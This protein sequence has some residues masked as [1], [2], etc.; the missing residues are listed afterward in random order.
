VPTAPD[1]R[2]D[3]DLVTADVVGPPRRVVDRVDPVLVAVV[4]AGVVLRWVGLGA[5]SLW[6]DEWLTS[7]A[8]AGSLPDLF[9]HVAHREGIPPTYFVVEWAWVR[10]AGDGEV[11][12]RTLSALFGA[13]TVP[14]AYAV[15]AE[16]RQPRAAARGAAVLVAVS[17]MLVWY[18][19][20]ARPYS[21][22]ALLG[23]VSFLLFARVWRDDA[24]RHL[25]V[26]AAVAAATVAVHYFAAFL[27]ATE[28]LA[29]LARRPPQWRRLLLAA[30]PSAGVLALLAP[31]AVTQHSHDANRLWISG[32]PLGDR[33]E[34]AGRSALVG[35]SPVHGRLW[36]AVAA[37]VAVAAV[38]LVGSGDRA[39][40]SAAALAAGVGGAALVPPLVLAAA[41]GDD[42]VVG[43]YL[44]ASL[45]PL[46]AAVAIGL[47]AGPR[48]V[49]LPALAVASAVSLVVVVGVRRDP[50]L[51]KPDW[52]AVA[53][54]GDG[55]G[56]RALVLGNH[57]SI[58]SPLVDYVTGGVSL[59]GDDR[60]LVDEVAVVS[61]RPSAKPCNFLV[62]RACA[63]VFLGAPL[64]EATAAQLELVERVE[65]DQFVVERFR[66][67][68]GPVSVG[69]ADLVDPQRL[70][71][72]LVVV[73]PE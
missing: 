21:L 17:P 2:P 45:V 14:V 22:I 43:R 30:L 57:R 47:A 34:E 66:A 44:V 3:A 26:W 67:P 50:D 35:P 16:L 32:F 18:S 1:A 42:V 68:D 33:L 29:L 23:A 69:R 59:E 64:P 15:V 10:L 65:L 48:A 62:G 60:A 61:A 5:Q 40:R 70:D 51:Q 71:D 13:A 7:E 19:Q 31:M 73:E 72:A 38:A 56:R 12:L 36:I 11:A 24:P 63:L 4:V 25:A 41:G 9:R 55:G 6:Y 49:G 58:A 53:A 52:D 28:G 46:V 8:V 54:A 37:V 27:I 39:A 20:E